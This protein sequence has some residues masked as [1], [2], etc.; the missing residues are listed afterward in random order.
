MLEETVISIIGALAVVL[1]TLLYFRHTVATLKK[2][3]SMKKVTETVF[4]IIDNV[5]ADEE[6][7]KRLYTLGVIVGSGAMKG[8][9]FQKGSGKFSISDLIGKAAASF[10]GINMNEGPSPPPQQQKSDLH[11]A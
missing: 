9:G 8:T 11:S 3:F 2:E 1:P 6:F 10:L 7:Q 5:T 4:E